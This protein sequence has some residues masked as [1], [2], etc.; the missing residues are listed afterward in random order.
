[1]EDLDDFIEE[2]EKQTHSCSDPD[3]WKKLHDMELAEK[4]P[5]VLFL[6]T[7]QQDLEE[8]VKY[9]DY[10][11]WRYANYYTK[12]EA[13]IEEQEDKLEDYK[14][15]YVAQKCNQQDPAT[16]KFYSVAYAERLAAVETF[17]IN[18]KGVIRDLRKKARQIKVYMEALV[19]KGSKLPGRQGTA[20]RL[21][22]MER[23]I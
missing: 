23:D 17:I 7:P 4:D 9:I 12:L 5:L 8:Q 22:E 20:N 15:S 14:N 16:G 19:R 2:Q 13:A 3:R 6:L 10:L 18:T 21:L 11:W 1:M